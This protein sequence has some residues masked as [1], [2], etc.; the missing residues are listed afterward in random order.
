MTAEGPLRRN[1]RSL[2]APLAW[3]AVV[4]ACGERTGARLL[5]QG[6]TK[7]TDWSYSRLD[8]GAV[9]QLSATL[10]ASVTLGTDSA[11]TPRSVSRVELTRT[12]IF[13][14]DGD[15]KAV[16]RFD[17]RGRQEF[18]RFA[19][20]APTAELKTPTGI[21]VVGDT[22]YVVDMDSRRG[23]F[24]IDPHGS[25]VPAVPSS[26]RATLMGVAATRG[27]LAMASIGSDRAITGDSARFL[28]LMSRGGSHVASVCRPDPE[29][30]AS[31][32]RR[33]LFE[34]YR[35]TGVSALDGRF[36]CRQPISPI[37]QV[38]DNRGRELPSIRLAPPFYERGADAPQ[39]MNQRAMDRFAATWTEHLDFFPTADGFLSVYARFDAVNASRRYRFFRCWTS[40][41]SAPRCGVGE[42]PSR[43]VGF[44]PPDSLLVID[45]PQG[46]A[47]RTVLQFLR[48][49]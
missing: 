44:L 31:L 2:L 35:A 18:S 48:V 40:R 15:P 4:I 19:G 41:A 21:A 1:R 12:A 46:S 37:V 23:T 43:P 6:A 34:L 3:V 29:Y 5:E 26:A 47:G 45:Y 42:T 32:A 11:T 7:D 14:L 10:A 9:A 39:S 36:Y 33:G 30:A 22:V 27:V 38:F 17:R 49:Q 8:S 13:V 28:S 20:R 16:R 24:V 25:L